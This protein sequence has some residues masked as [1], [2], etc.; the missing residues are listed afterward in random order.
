MG[1]ARPKPEW[2]AQ[3]L[4]MIRMALGISQAEMLKRLELEETMHASRISEYERGSR[5]P[6]LMTLVK[7][8]HV[9]CIHLEDIANDELE[10]PARLP[11][12]VKYEGIKRTSSSK[13]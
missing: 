6:S 10:L 13:K 5:E 4:G 1:H 8:A 12:N 2:L 3:K 9:A 11:G 7:Y